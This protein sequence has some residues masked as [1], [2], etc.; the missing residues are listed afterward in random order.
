MPEEEKT[1]STKSSVQVA[2][3]EEAK[4]TQDRILGTEGEKAKA[5][6]EKPGE[7]KE[8]VEEKEKAKAAAEAK[9]KEAKPAEAGEEDAKIDAILS[10][11]KDTPDADKPKALAKAYREIE[12][13]HGEQGKE[14]GDLRKTELWVKQLQEELEKDLPNTLKKLEAHYGAKG[15]D[16]NEEIVLDRKTIKGIVEEQLT[17]KETDKQWFDDQG[18]LMKDRH[19]DWDELADKRTALKEAV[20]LGKFPFN[21]EIFHLAVRGAASPEQLLADAKK[22]VK[23][24]EADA[25]A[26]KM[27]EQTQTQAGG[28]EEKK[29]QTYQEKKE[30]SV[31]TSTERAAG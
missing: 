7:T 11:F 9:E 15:E 10:R 25:L 5:A 23:Q 24:D 2:S 17:Q 20:R 1:D 3:E 30:E 18:K 8:K 19:K 6:E 26:A 21:D 29:E 27:G 14:I 4:A 22:I 16:E 13:L 28:A 31:L 12:K